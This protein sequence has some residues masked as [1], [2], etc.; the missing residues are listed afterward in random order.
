MSIQT[1][2]ASEL[3]QV[4]ET[5]P[6]VDLIDVRTP[7][8]FAAVH[9]TA[10]RNIPL[11]QL[12]ASKVSAARKLPNQPLYVICRSGARSR[13]ACEKLLAA[14]LGNI[15]SVEG[16]TQA[17][18]QANLSLT[19]SEV[20]GIPLDRQVRIAAG[21]LVVAGVL[22][23]ELVHPWGYWLAAGVGAGLVYAGVT[24]HCPMGLALARMPWNRQGQTCQ[25]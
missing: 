19:R 23:G 1:I 2:S 21:L 11:D 9:V 25:R 24:D 8:E 5:Q 10:A 18:E 12:D 6:D 15:V 16:G 13:Q 3:R 7:M 22:A 4:L 17:C 20:K 14:G